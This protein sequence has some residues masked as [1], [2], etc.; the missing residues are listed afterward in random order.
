[1]SLGYSI[2]QKVL[3]R[4]IPLEKVRG[5]SR[6]R[7]YVDPVT[8]QVFT[9]YAIQKAKNF[10]LTPAQAAA[11][12]QTKIG[13]QTAYDIAKAATQRHEHMPVLF[14]RAAQMSG[15]A[16]DK[17]MKDKDFWRNVR[18]LSKSKR[19]KSKGRA[20]YYFSYSA[21]PTLYDDGDGDD[22]SDIDDE[23][24]AGSF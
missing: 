20:L 8:G 17:L 7:N 24:T 10:G 5:G 23:F 12:R 6:A 4:I 15:K 21:T 18:N 9:Q 1:M 19:N 16:K 2:P 3:D 13:K 22:F 14:E 11:A